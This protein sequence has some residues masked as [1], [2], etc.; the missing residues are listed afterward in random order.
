MIKK[1]T[2]EVICNKL[3]PDIYGFDDAKKALIFQYLSKVSLR[4]L[5]V[6]E[7]CSGKSIFVNAIKKL[8]INNLIDE[9]NISLGKVI[10][11]E[12]YI[13][14]DQ[15][16]ELYREEIIN[17]LNES[18]L[19]DKNLLATIS[20]QNDDYLD[21]NI[22]KKFELILFLENKSN[23]NQD[24]KI[25]DIFYK[26]LFEENSIKNIDLKI[27]NY[28]QKLKLKKITITTEVKDELKKFYLNIRSKNSRLYETPGNT[29]TIKFLNTISTLTEIYSKL[30]G[31]S[32]TKL[33]D[34]NLAKDFFLSCA[35]NI[36]IGWGEISYNF[37][38]FSKNIS[39]ENIKVFLDISLI[40]FD[41]LEKKE[42]I[43]VSTIIDKIT[44]V[45][46]DYSSDMVKE[47]LDILLLEKIFTKS[48]NGVYKFIN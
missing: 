7:D 47:V 36:G 13:L 44:K 41:F 6:G 2:L 33:S 25:V 8:E 5:F 11:T 46:L 3:F 1:F 26:E 45:N 48:K 32:K 20:S 19:E 42:S 29:F 22:I 27:M 14:I 18:N 38:F 15:L 43:R 30:N 9:F 4:V 17:Y 23:M 37:E 12:N 28:L 40:L 10:L 31:N 21:P 34:F 24:K 39:N 35:K 16:D